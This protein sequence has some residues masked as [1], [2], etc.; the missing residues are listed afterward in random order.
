MKRNRSTNPPI[1][2]YSLLGCGVVATLDGGREVTATV[3]ESSGGAGRLREGD[4]ATTATGR[5]ALRAGGEGMKP[6]WCGAA[7]TAGSE[8]DA[9][10]LGG[11]HDTDGGAPHAVVC[12]CLRKRAVARAGLAPEDGAGAEAYSVAVGVTETAANVARRPP[13][14][15]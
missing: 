8:K 10:R 7:R 4:V 1:T 13:W 5:T 2:L 3:T 14:G 11:A 9:G 6:R 12:D 15:V